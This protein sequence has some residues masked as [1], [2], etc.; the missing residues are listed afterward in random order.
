MPC[1][2]CAFTYAAELAVDTAGIVLLSW[3][4]KSD[5]HILLTVGG[6][7]MNQPFNSK[8]STT[9]HLNTIRF[10]VIKLATFIRN[11]DL[12]VEVQVD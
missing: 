3:H 10:C 9:P 1:Y 5:L 7:V 11:S 8:I 6:N 2:A 12:S 4:R